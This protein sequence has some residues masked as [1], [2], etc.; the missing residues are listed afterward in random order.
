MKASTNFFPL[1]AIALILMLVEYP[2][3]AESAYAGDCANPH[4]NDCTYY[5]Q[6]LATAVPCTG[7]DE[8]AISYG[9]NFCNRYATAY[10][11]FST[12][13]KLWINA[14]RKCLQVKLAAYLKP[15]PRPTCSALKR[16]AF[17]THVPCYINPGS[18]APS[19]C[20][21]LL[22]SDLLKI[23]N[24]I[25]SS[26]TTDLLNTVKAGFETVGGCSWSLVASWLS[27]G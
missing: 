23:V 5:R 6:C 13:G 20:S 4:G 18:G 16:Y 27:S 25:K 14:V 10:N 24:T 12:Q 8:Y 22:S 17:D 21:V 11:T 2:R 3:K 26:L 7:A 9:E 15:N 1:A 19:F